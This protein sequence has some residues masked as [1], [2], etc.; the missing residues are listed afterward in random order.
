MRS[1]RTPRAPILLGPFFLPG[2]GWPSALL[3]PDAGAE[4]NGGLRARSIGCKTRRYWGQHVLSRAAAIGRM[5][6]FTI[7][8][9]Q[10]PSK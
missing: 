5:P 1:A 7:N 2:A 9:L 3:D 6:C 4:R 10:R 8:E